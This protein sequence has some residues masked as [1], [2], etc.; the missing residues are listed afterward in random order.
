MSDV[1]ISARN[2]TKTYRLYTKPHYRFLDVLGLLRGDGKYSEHHALHAINLDIRRGE[3]VALIG[4]NGAGKSTLLK[5]ITGVTQPTSGSMA[6][7]SHASA[8]LQIGTT[9]HPEFTGRENVLSYLAHLGITGGPAMEKLFEIIE[10]SELE[11]YIDQPVKTYSTGMG[12]RL[13]FAASTVMQPEL[14]VIDEILSVGDAYFAKKSF[15]RIE[16][17]CSGGYTTLVLVSHDIYSASTLCDRMIWIDS[18]RVMIDGASALVMKAY[19]DS[20]RVQE[21]SR[22]RRNK[23]LKLE[24]AHRQNGEGQSDT[25]LVEICTRG[26]KP[27]PQ[28]IAIGR[29]DIEGPEG[30]ILKAPIATATGGDDMSEPFLDIAVGVWGSAFERDGRFV[31]PML[32]HGSPFNKIVVGFPRIDKGL[33]KK[34]V[35]KLDIA[36]DTEACLNVRAYL[37][38]R[39]AE[40]GSIDVRTGGEWTTSE[41]SLA[42]IASMTAGEPVVN[43]VSTT[44]VHG[45][46]VIRILSVRLLNAFQDEVDSIQHSDMFSIELSLDIRDPEFQGNPQI[47]LAFQKDGVLDVCRIIERGL[48][49]DAKQTRAVVVSANFPRCQL[50]NGT[51]T[52][53]VMIA[54]QDYY[55]KPQTIFFSINPGVYACLSRV[56]EFSVSGGGMVGSGTGFVADALWSSSLQ[57]PVAQR[58]EELTT[59][60]T[61]TSASLDEPIPNLQ[62]A[63]TPKIVLNFP[64]ELLNEFPQIA[65]AALSA[66]DAIWNEVKFKSLDELSRNSPALNGF[67]WYGYL[68]LSAIRVGHTHRAL[69]MNG[70]SAGK[71][72]DLGSYLGNFALTLQTLDYE[73]DA[74]DSYGKYGPSLAP[75]VGLLKEAGVGVL[76]FDHIGYSLEGIAPE[77]Y[78]AVLLMGVIEHIPHT[79]KG[80]LIAVDRVLRPGGILI[81][82]TPNLAYEYKRASLS[83]GNPINCPIQSQFETEIPFEGHHRE[84]LTEEVVWM[85]KRISHEVLSVDHFN[86]SCYALQELSGIDAQR[87]QVMQD[88]PLRR[89]IILAVS[90][91]SK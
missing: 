91:T 31:R 22:L 52:V 29:I 76:D 30:R 53:S 11:E 71:V 47:L 7:T 12:A 19:E 68:R 26:N 1:I 56:L 28:P 63:D 35:L 9:F 5:L 4:R 83:C 50:G 18:G 10:F 24:V 84:Y 87:Y 36:N 3:K 81:L 79:P 37:G 54:E 8:L 86:Y 69:Q 45:T 62:L 78:D 40:L 20:I 46:G 51:Y 90:R 42:H 89:E 82:D 23:L 66:A 59:H 41:M 39:S 58:D 77:S 61:G 85:L 44:G 55:D 48:R 67:D 27:L 80:L 64:Q 6:V 17:L 2:V 15:E 38:K 88:D 57:R 74:V 75:I 21:E 70:L 73:V 60:P 25:L 43:E 32:D 72:L 49:L 16:E 34:S 33:L 14:L 65:S 13:M